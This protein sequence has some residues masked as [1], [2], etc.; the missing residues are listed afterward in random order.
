M[1][2][3]DWLSAVDQHAI[4]LMSTGMSTFAKRA[5]NIGPARLCTHRDVE[6]SETYPGRVVPERS[7]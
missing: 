6:P 4:A 3:N 5:A 2:R 1:R 7:T